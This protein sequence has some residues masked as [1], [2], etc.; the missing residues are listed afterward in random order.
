MWSAEAS[1]IRLSWKPWEGCAKHVAAASAFL[2]ATKAA[3]CGS[4]RLTGS[5]PFGPP[6]SRSVSGRRVLA[7]AGR[8]RR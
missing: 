8:K 6:T 2:A 3:R 1:T 5:V 7:A 4:A